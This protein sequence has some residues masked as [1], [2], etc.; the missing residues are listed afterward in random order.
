MENPE[1][2][3]NSLPVLDLTDYFP[4]FDDPFVEKQYRMMSNVESNQSSLEQIHKILKEM[5]QMMTEFYHQPKTATPLTN[6]ATE[7][8]KMP[9]LHASTP[10]RS[11]PAVF[12]NVE[13][14]DDNET[15]SSKQG[16]P[17]ALPKSIFASVET[18]ATSS[19]P[20][21][22]KRSTSLETLNVAKSIFRS[23]DFLASSACPKSIGL[24]P[25]T[26]GDIQFNIQQQGKTVDTFAFVEM[27]GEESVENPCCNDD[28][29]L[30]VD[31]SD[32]A[33]E[34]K[35]SK[36][37]ND[38]NDVSMND[39]QQE[40]ANTS[41]N[42][43]KIIISKPE[44]WKMT[45]KSVATCGLKHVEAQGHI[46]PE[47]EKNDPVYLNI[48]EDIRGQRNEHRQKFASALFR[49][50]CTIEDVF[51]KNINGRVYWSGNVG[52][53]K[54]NP[55]KVTD[56]TEISFRCFPCTPTEEK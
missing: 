10:K 28:R 36:E 3:N 29:S 49:A 25:L 11:V 5:R 43:S 52:K 39:S 55:T 50:M 7:T 1:P 12:A 41:F 4:E 38:S 8:E 46:L 33:T 23:V 17:Q 47:Y 31:S 9:S 24:E 26:S 19:I 54:V 16:P 45:V 14:P 18:L 30:E 48:V 20:T 35:D 34:E 40:E 44:F 13:M 42:G 51:K 32:A 56:I 37:E 6:Q 27:R 2:K 15:D 22:T 53:A 21:L